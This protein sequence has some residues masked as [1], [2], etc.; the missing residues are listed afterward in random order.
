MAERKKYDE[1][2]KEIGKLLSIRRKALGE[3][4]KTREQF[5][6]LR[7][8]ELFGGKAWISPRHL[9]NIELGKNWISF[10]K[11]F[12]LALALETDPLELFEEIRKIYCMTTE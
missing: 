8:D 12:D 1:K 4:Y 7:A 9:A 5:I 3:Q 6:D 10:E 2:L 11:F